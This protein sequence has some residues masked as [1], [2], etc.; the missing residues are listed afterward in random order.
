MPSYFIGIECKV[1]AKVKKGREK[2]RPLKNTANQ[3][4]ALI[5]D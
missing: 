5:L 1:A 3:L 4:E 2:T